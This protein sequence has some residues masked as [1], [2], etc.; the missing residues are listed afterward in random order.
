VAYAAA[1]F[2]QVAAVALRTGGTDDSAAPEASNQDPGW[3]RAARIATWG[4][5]PLLVLALV[6]GFVWDYGPDL[7]P[8]GARVDPRQA[9]IR[10]VWFAH[11]SLSAPHNPYSLSGE[12]DTSIWLPRTVSSAVLVVLVWLAMLLMVSR[13]QRARTPGALCVV[14][15]CWGVVAV[16]A[17]LVGLIEGALVRE[18][19][20]AVTAQLW[21]LEVAAHGV[22]FAAV[23]GWTIGVAVVLA[24]RF[25][26]GARADVEAKS[27]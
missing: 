10:L 6:G 14:V 1:A 24:Y 18:E 11:A 13:W 8:Y 12:F 3:A 20:F 19:E 26:R 2:V 17:A 15:Q 27:H 21:A 22:R 9:W 16:L 5:L 4:A 25:S 7:D 23:F